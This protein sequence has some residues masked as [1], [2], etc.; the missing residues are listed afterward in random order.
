[1][2]STAGSST[3]SLSHAVRDDRTAVRAVTA[4]GIIETANVIELIFDVPAGR[5]ADN[6]FAPLVEMIPLAYPE[7]ADLRHEYA[8]L[9]PKDVAWVRTLRN[10]IAAHIDLR[11]PLHELIR[12]LDRV[13]PTRLTNLFHKTVNSLSR[14][15]SRHG[16]T[17]MST[18]VRLRRRTVAGISRD[19]P[20]AFSP[21]YEN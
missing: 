6:R 4:G 14:V 19:Q 1:M 17:V 11:S 13:D 8:L 21:D 7:A 2:P 3:A 10:S 16:I 20:P 5:S 15:D 18:L 9:D 12:Q